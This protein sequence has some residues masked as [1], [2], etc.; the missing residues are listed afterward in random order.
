MGEVIS[1]RPR[2]RLIQGRQDPGFFYACPQCGAEV[3][4]RDLGQVIAH[5]ERHSL[6]PE[7][8]S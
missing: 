6:P 5:T 3:D 8:A 7:G 4:K 2:Y 1:F